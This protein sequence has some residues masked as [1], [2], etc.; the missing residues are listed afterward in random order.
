MIL[1]F[2]SCLQYFYLRA[3]L[4]YIPPLK[5]FILH[6]NWDIKALCVKKSL[7]LQILRK[8][9]SFPPPS[10]EA[11]TGKSLNC[12]SLNYPYT[13]DI[14]LWNPCFMREFPATFVWEG[15]SWDFYLLCFESCESIRVE[16]TSLQNFAEASPK[17]ETFLFTYIIKFLFSL[18]FEAVFSFFH[19]SRWCFLYFVWDV[20]VGRDIQSS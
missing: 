16:I 14:A 12:P 1:A 5:F 18:H 2:A 8:D 20:S 11:E 6:M 13:K 3:S 4:Y 19:A 7:W 17:T 9:L 10:T 15:R